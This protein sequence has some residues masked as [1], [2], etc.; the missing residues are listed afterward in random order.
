MVRCFPALAL[1]LAA[2]SIEPSR[3]NAPPGDAAPPEVRKTFD[4][5]RLDRVVSRFVAE[6]GTVDYAALA[7][8]RA[9]LDAYLASLATVV[10]DRL[11]SRDEQMAYWINAYN[12]ITLAGVLRFYPTASV[13]D[14]RGFWARIITNCGGR[15]LSLD[16]IEHEILRPMG[17]PRV[18]AAINCASRSCPKL[19]NEAYV[20]E[21]LDG[22]LDA[23]CRAF[24]ASTER[25]RFD[26]RARVAHLSKVFAWFAA[27]FAVEPYGSVRGFVR[28]YAPPQE[29]LAEEF[30]VR[31]LAYDWGLNDRA[32]RR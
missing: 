20:G 19:R 24:L 7:G 13:K 18:H 26:H 16:Q 8:D 12:A 23:Q 22:Q 27:D 28:R 1:C 29:W 31:Y 21:R 17:D 32:A 14:H 3:T 4:H 15:D 5:G 9:D 11:G 10:P 6:D 25:N 2:C 30:E